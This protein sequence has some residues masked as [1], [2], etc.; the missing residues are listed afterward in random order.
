MTNTQQ[1]KAAKRFAQKWQGK[2]SEKQDS[3]RVWM[4]LLTTVY[5]IE[6]PA[7]LVRFEVPVKLSHTSYADILVPSTHTLIE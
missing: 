5:G 6:N 4:D 2:G 7:D 3:Q 1:E